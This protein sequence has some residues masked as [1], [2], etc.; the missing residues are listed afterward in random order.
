MKIDLQ[1]ALYKLAWVKFG[2]E[3]TLGYALSRDHIARL[4]PVWAPDL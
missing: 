1:N 3:L 4:G 2:L